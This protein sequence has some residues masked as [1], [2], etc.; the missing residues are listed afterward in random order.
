MLK[1]LNQKGKFLKLAMESVIQF[2]P[3]LSFSI[4]IFHC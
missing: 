1:Y 3:Y 2:K 4:F